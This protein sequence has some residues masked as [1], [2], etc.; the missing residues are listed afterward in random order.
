MKKENEELTR[1]YNLEKLEFQQDG[2]KLVKMV[3]ELMIE[4]IYFHSQTRFLYNTLKSLLHL[5]QAYSQRMGTK[6]PVPIKLIK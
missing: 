2:Y 4:I 1:T 6:Y 5:M 3:N